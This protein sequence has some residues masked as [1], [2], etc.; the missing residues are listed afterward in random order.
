[1]LAMLRKREREDEEVEEEPPI[2]MAGLGLS[3]L[4]REAAAAGEGARDEGAPPEE[5]MYEPC[6]LRS[7]RREKKRFTAK[8]RK[9]SECFFC[10]RAGERGTILKKEEVN[11]MI[12]M[13]RQNTGQMESVT[14][15]EMVADYYERF[16]QRVNAKLLPGE[17]MLPPMTERTVLD[18]IR[19]HHQ[20]PEV[21]KLVQ[22]EELQELREDLVDMVLERNKVTKRMRVNKTVMDALEKV[23]K[24][25]WAVQAK[26]PSKCVGYKPNARVAQGVGE[27][28]SVVSTT[29][30]TLYDFWKQRRRA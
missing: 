21:K 30:K 16:R 27:P 12:E 24:L 1:M 26:D 23:V 18:H 6:G 10:S 22:L 14:L 3:D 9:R 5:E 13:L 2:T 28:G 29:N 8:A 25:E 4:A 7:R 11:V 17:T 19:R 20:D 15:A